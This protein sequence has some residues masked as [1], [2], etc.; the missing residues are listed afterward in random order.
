MRYNS[1]E[2]K[3]KRKKELG[4]EHRIHSSLLLSLYTSLSCSTESS[5]ERL[6]GYRVDKKDFSKFVGLGLRILRDY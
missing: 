1:N 4:V 2:E 5:T 3:T 6:V